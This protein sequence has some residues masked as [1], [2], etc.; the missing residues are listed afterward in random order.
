MISP[1]R[2]PWTSSR[3]FPTR[4]FAFLGNGAHCCLP[5]RQLSQCSLRHAQST[6]THATCPATPCLP[7][8]QSSGDRSGHA[9]TTPCR[10]ALLPG[11]PVARRATLVCRASSW[12]APP[13]RAACTCSRGCGGCLRRSAPGS[14]ARLTG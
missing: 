3:R 13:W 6:G 9:S 10:F 1:H 5:A 14:L 4:K 12:C 2:S 8:L 7:K 11:T